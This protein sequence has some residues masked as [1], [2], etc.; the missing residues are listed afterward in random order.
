M[1]VGAVRVAAPCGYTIYIMFLVLF[2]SLFV[3]SIV[4]MLGLRGKETKNIINTLLVGLCKVLLAPSV[5]RG[6]FRLNKKLSC[7]TGILYK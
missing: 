6:I 3:A 2:C 7:Q 4:L 1:S 5:F